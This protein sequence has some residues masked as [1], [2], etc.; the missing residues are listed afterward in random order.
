[1]ATQL[2]FWGYLALFFIKFFLALAFSLF[3]ANIIV[4]NI[5]LNPVPTN[6]LTDEFR[7]KY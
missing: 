5:L 6:A 3:V 7:R 2:H 4:I 1:M